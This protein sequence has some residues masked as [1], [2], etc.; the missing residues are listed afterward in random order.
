MPQKMTTW[1]LIRHALIG[2]MVGVSIQFIGQ[3]SAALIHVLQNIP[4]EPAA[5]AAGISKYLWEIKNRIP[6]V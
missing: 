2:V 6:Y 3:L 1:E 4:I 5:M